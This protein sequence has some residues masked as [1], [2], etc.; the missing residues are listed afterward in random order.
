[1]GY[2]ISKY[3][4]KRFIIVKSHILTLLDIFSCPYAL[5]VLSG[6]I[7]IMSLSSNLS[8]ESLLPVIR[9]ISSE[10]SCYRF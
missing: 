4:G 7:L 2:T 9:V 3:N 5:L 6:I 1:M 10:N 8:E